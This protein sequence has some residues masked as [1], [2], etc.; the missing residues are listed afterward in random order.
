MNCYFTK[1]IRLAALRGIISDLTFDSS[2]EDI[3][4]LS[5]VL[6]ELF[7]TLG[8]EKALGVG[9]IFFE[10]L[11]VF[12]KQCN[13]GIFEKD[14]KALAEAAHK[15][16]GASAMLGQELLEKPLAQLEIDAQN[17]AIKDFSGRIQ[18]LESISKQSEDMFSNYVSLLIK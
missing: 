17:D 2:F 9:S 3:G 7:E 6:K 15:L 11:E 4:E 10:E 14:N 18:R 8:I 5:T 13:Q 12:I 16:K 1:P